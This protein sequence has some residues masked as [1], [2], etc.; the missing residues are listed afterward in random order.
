MADLAPELVSFIYD[1]YVPAGRTP[2]VR[3]LKTIV[4]KLVTTFIDVRVIVDAIDEIDYSQHK[5][6]IKTLT[7]FAESQEN[8]KI[9]SSSQNIPSIFSYLKNKPELALG[10]EAASVAADIDLFVTATIDKLNDNHSG[11]IPRK[12]LADMRRL[13]LERAEGLIHAAASSWV[14]KMM[15]V[16]IF[17]CV[18]LVLE[19]LGKAV[20]IKD[21]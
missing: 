19:I 14:Y 2:S 11:D 3:Y 7:S 18:Y 20:T 8:F 13:I 5:E 15:N 4:P 1:E 16:G 12:V 9:V 10:A 6:L 17:L 21:L